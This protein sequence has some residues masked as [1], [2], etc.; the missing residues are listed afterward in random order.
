MEKIGD[1]TFS[2]IQ[3][4][5]SQWGFRAERTKI[6]MII[7]PAQLQEKCKEQQLL[8]YLAFVDL[9]NALDLITREGVFSV[10]ET[11]ECPPAM[12]RIIISSHDGMRCCVY[13]DET[14]SGTFPVHPGVKHGCMVASNPVGIF[15]W[16]V[17][18]TLRMVYSY[19]PELKGAYSISPDWMLWLRLVR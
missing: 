10:L 7:T 3:N 14:M 4:N 8:L 9:T 15:F 1:T 17:S 13:F 16:V 18:R 5:I 11:V 12:I 6:V 2:W 19:I